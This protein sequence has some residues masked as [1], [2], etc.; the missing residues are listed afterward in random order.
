MIIKDPG[1][2][3]DRI[4][5]LGRDESC[6]YLVDGGDEA[7]LLGG[8]MAYIIPDVEKQIEDFKIDVKKIRRLVIHHSHFDHVGVIPYFKKKWPWATITASE[9]A[10]KQ[11]VRPK[12]V[13]V[14]AGLNLAILNDK[15]M[16]GRADELG[17]NVD[18]I[19]VDETM[20]DGD[21]ALL[22]DLTLQFLYV[23]GH[24]SCSMAVYIPE[25]KALSASDA[26]GIP[27][28]DYVFAAANSNFDLYQQSLEKMAELDVNVHMAEHYGALTEEDGRGYMKKAIESAAATRRL[29]EDVYA[30][31]KDEARTT[32]EIIEV[33]EK[34]AAGYFLPKEIMS[35]VVGQMTRFIANK[36]N[37]G[38]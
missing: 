32:G 35:M 13:E 36:A 5:L 15:G 11:L 31:T 9:T 10:G 7:A 6:V 23:P 37:A 12:V 16:G 24:S 18:S 38:S 1:K 25:E 26:G 19:I 28:G 33:M 30:K 3:T 20:G 8:G 29:I 17:V 27:Y 34:E 4:T 21:Q 22:G 2:V 14:I